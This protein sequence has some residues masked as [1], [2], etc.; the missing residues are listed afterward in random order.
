MD[1]SRSDKLS[2]SKSQHTRR[3][4]RLRS[5]RTTR[6][7]KV[8][9]GV[10]LGVGFAAINTG[11]NLLYLVLGLLLSVIVLS[12]ILSDLSLH[13]L[14]FNRTLPRRAFAGLP[15]LVEIEVKNN[16][17]F[18]PSY[19]IEV[20][21]RIEGRRIDK[22]CYFLKVSARARQTAAYRRIPPVRGIE[23][24]VGLRV[25][26]RFPFGLIEKW[27]EIDL[28]QEHLVY[29]SP[30]RT[31]RPAT[32][33]TITGDAQPQ[34]GHGHQEIDGVRELHEGEPV[35]DID[36]KK[37]AS[38]QKL[39]VRER[40]PEQSPK[41]RLELANRPPAASQNHNGP[42]PSRE[43]FARRIELDIRRTAW[44]ALDALRQGATVEILAH[45]GGTGTPRILRTLPSNNAADR[46]LA[47][48]AKLP[49]TPQPPEVIP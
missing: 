10:T 19:S 14:E 4:S 41:I 34:Q 28:V 11:N 20:E 24:Y 36:W 44:I 30:E 25:A 43:S 9:V 47:F 42:P 35:R 23:R 7:G 26:T 48:L 15:M 18:V 37:S 27:R 31:T 16:K 17:R 13:G 33:S 2:L 8:F 5:W 12:G 38:A 21:D 1:A 22:R 29:P 39:I 49:P 6:E 46:V 3:L 45:D 32:S 40:R